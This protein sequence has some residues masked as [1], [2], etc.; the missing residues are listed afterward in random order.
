MHFW[1]Q[2]LSSVE[3]VAVCAMVV[4][5]VMWT[6]KP[7]GPYE[8]YAFLASVVGITIVEIFRRHFRDRLDQQSKVNTPGQP[9]EINSPGTRTQVQEGYLDLNSLANREMRIVY[10]EPFNSRPHL[11]L[12]VESI[13]GN[14][15]ILAAEDE[16][17]FTIVRPGFWAGGTAN[18]L[19]WRATGR[20]DRP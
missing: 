10:P 15:V 12:R 8:P 3:V 7:Q 17:G 2:L 13:V 20:A 16:I 1:K 6:R 5:G 11:E 9:S 18:T 14:K 19:H 4:L